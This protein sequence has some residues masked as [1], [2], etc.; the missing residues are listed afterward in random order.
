MWRYCFVLM[1]DLDNFKHLNDTM[2]H[3]IGDL[4]LIEVASTPACFRS[5]RAIRWRGWAE[6]SL[7]SFWQS[8]MKPLRKP[9]S[10]LTPSVT[11]FQPH[12]ANLYLL[13]GSEYRGS[14]SIGISLFNSHELTETELLKQTDTAMYQAKNARRRR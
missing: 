6:M 12:S 7:L 9:L 5:K 3:H 10:R 4:L 8:W 14:T 11:R 1:L 2:G 13:K